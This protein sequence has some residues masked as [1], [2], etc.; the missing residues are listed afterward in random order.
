MINIWRLFIILFL[1]HTISSISVFLF[2]WDKLERIFSRYLT[3]NIVAYFI[4]SIV[5]LAI[6][7]RALKF[8]LSTWKLVVIGVIVPYLA[9]V[10]SYLLMVI[11]S[12]WWQ[13]ESLTKYGEIAPLFLI[14]TFVPYIA[15]KGFI[16]SLE[17]AAFIL[18]CR[19]YLRLCRGESG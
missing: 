13:G 6:I 10:F 2:Y 8:P 3:L 1:S 9:S 11:I 18:I 17:S 12:T 14:A 19:K 15:L 5:V 16:I 7:V 4:V